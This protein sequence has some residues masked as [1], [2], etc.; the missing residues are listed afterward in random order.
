MNR[1]SYFVLFFAF[2]TA[3][4]VNSAPAASRKCEFAH[5]QMKEFCEGSLSS[6]DGSVGACVG[7]QI[8]VKASC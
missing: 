2:A 6:Y 5:Q 4:I 1:Y 3:L 7:A 8:A